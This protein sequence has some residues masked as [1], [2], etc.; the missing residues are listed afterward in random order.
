MDLLIWGV[1]AALSVAL[2][3]WVAPRT[4]AR[5]LRRARG[6]HSTALGRVGTASALDRLFDPLEVAHPGQSGIATVLDNADAFAARAVS[7]GLA[8]RSLDLMYYLWRTDLTGWLLIDT[9]VSA[10]DRGVRVRLLLDD[11]NVQGLDRTFLALSQHPMI[12]VR[13]FNPTRN[14]GLAV[15]RLIE[16]AL[17]LARFNRRMH[18]KLWI[19]DGR[20]VILGGRNIGDTYFGADD[21]APVSIDAD[22][23][24]VGEQVA[25]VSGLFDSYWN[26]A[27]SLPIRALWPAL[28]LSNAGFRRRVARKT[29]EVAARRFVDLTVADRSPA[30]VLTARLRWTHKVTLLADPP[31]KAYGTPSGSGMSGAIDGLMTG[32]QAEVLLITPYFVPG[33]AWMTELA[34]LCERGIRVCLLTNALSV[35]DNVLVHGAYRHYRAR[36]LAGGGI[37][38]EFAR[39]GQSDV[40]HSKVFV[41]DRRQA[42]IGSLN[43]DLRSALTNTELG[44]LFEEPALVAELVAKFDE[45]SAPGQAFAVRQVGR[46]LI[47]DVRRPCLPTEMTLEPEATALRR[48]ISWT[49]GHLPIKHYL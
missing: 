12:E 7:G 9:L 42:V 29:H 10:A 15:R 17:G 33:S 4:S 47:W 19:A 30:Q 5:F 13:L 32:A 16:M 45:L 38:Y 44:L 6:A 40:L 22:V 21:G 49:V 43:F 3:L 27:L 35:A 46:R 1:A 41:I 18:G 8:G 36:L 20:L 11:V 31:D 26:L 34:R 23:M 2:A 14:R 48:A 37:L 25:L 39:A 24:L 28:K